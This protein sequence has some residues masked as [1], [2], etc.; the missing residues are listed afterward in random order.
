M[1]IKYFNK[2]VVLHFLL[3]YCLGVQPLS[4][5]GIAT[6][7][8]LG[9][10]GYYATFDAANA[11]SILVKNHALQLGWFAQLNLGLLY[12]KVIP[13]F[14]FDWHTISQRASQLNRITFPVAV[15]IP[16]FNFLRPHVGLIFCLPLSDSTNDPNESLIKKYKEKI[17]SCFFGVG[18]ECGKWLLD[19]DFEVLFS[20]IAKEKIGSGLIDGKA[21]YRPKQF[22]L[23][24]GYNL[25]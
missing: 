23:K 11:K 6:G 22:A 12:A 14:V 18:I 15:G 3:A 25:L 13:L 10:A 7:P 24:V 2:R 16:L 20:S 1:N 5:I 4:A 21:S 19:F 8:T 17:N 9:L